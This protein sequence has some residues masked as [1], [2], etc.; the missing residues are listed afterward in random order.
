MIRISFIQKLIK[1]KN[2]FDS[3]CTR[4]DSENMS[5]K[6]FKMVTIFNVQNSQRKNAGKFLAQFAEEITQNK[7]SVDKIGPCT[8][9]RKFKK[10]RPTYYIYYNN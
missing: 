1:W 8:I 5:G 4:T 6:K 9:H 2:L 10:E 7:E 3:I